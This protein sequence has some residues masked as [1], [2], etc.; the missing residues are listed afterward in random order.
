VDSDRFAEILDKSDFAKYDY[1]CFANY[2]YFREPKFRAR[3]I[4]NSTYMVKRELIN[5]NLIF[6]HK[7]RANFTRLPN[8][9]DG[10]VRGFDGEPMIHHYS[11]VRTKEEMLRKV[12]S[13]GHSK[14]KNWTAL[15]EK[16][17][18]RE[19]NGTDF[20]YGYQYDV[21]EPYID[22]GL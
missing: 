13:W 9:L 11:W 16:E 21:V 6:H 14:V 17:F 5:Q 20:I 18:S 10:V 1:L 4:Q 3:H 2:W 19:F 22:L 12:R 7:N 8:S 15:V